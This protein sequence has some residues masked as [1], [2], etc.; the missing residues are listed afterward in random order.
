MHMLWK[1]ALNMRNKPSFVIVEAM[2]QYA[3][4]QGGDRN[5]LSGSIV[6]KYWPLNVSV[7]LAVSLYT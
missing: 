4:I 2:Q 6:D 5:K 7:Y 3:N 1:S